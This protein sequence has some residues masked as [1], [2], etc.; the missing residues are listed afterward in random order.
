[1]DLYGAMAPKHKQLD[2]V[3]FTRISKEE[4]EK[5]V[6]VEFATFNEKLEKEK[7][8]PKKLILKRPVGRPK[9][10]QDVVHLPKA[11]IMKKTS[12]K[13]RDQYRNWFNPNLW[14]PIYDA[15][16]QHRNIGDALNFLRSAYRKP[17]DLSCVYDYLSRGTMYGWFHS[18]GVL[19]DNIKRCVELGTYFAKSTQH[20]PILASYPLL[21]EEICEVLKKQRTAGQPL[22][23]VCIQGIIKAIISKRQPHLL[24]DSSGFCV[25]YKWTLAFIKA[26]MNWSYRAATTA[27]GKLPFDYE[28]QGKKMAERCAYLVKIHNIPEELVVNTDQTGVHLVPT[29]GARIWEKKILNM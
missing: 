7:T 2:L 11:T 17:G 16:K 25:S 3:F 19:K 27:A 8:M 15:V 10:N 21:K 28:V 26:E 13:V 18:N 29:G 4:R 1:V 22:Y 12:K 9:I 24:E 5:A 20:C 6:E 23:G 14:P